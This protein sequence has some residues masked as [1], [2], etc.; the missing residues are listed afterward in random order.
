VVRELV[1]HYHLNNLESLFY[2]LLFDAKTHR[3]ALKH[4]NNLAGAW[5][6]EN[7]WGTYLFWGLDEKL[8]RVRLKVDGGK[9]IAAND[10]SYAL[11][12]TP[13]AVASSLSQKKIFPSM[14]LCYLLISL[15]YGMKCLGGF[16]QVHDLT[17]I[18]QAWRNFLRELGHESEAEALLPVQTKELGGDGMVL[19]Y[20]K[21]K[22]GNLV[23]ATGI[24]MILENKRYSLEHYVD[25]S[26][27]VKMEHMMS[28]MLP[29]MYTVLYL[30]A[31]RD[32]RLLSVSPAEIL[33]TTPL[34]D[35]L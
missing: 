27:R 5:S 29:E 25:L 11:P 9:L 28:P 17:M 22:S 32:K 13:E 4:F 14:L 7:N 10:A 20:L 19:A 15:Y 24:D 33:K 31:E 16:C 23:P 1:V 34:Y 8:R 2:K 6:L 35:V 21:T 3:R 30:A 12:L 26:R 18:K